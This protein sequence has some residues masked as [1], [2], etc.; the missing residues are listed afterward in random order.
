MAMTCARC[1][2]Q[3]PDGNLYCQVCGTPL[4]A[5]ARVAAAPPPAVPPGPPPGAIQGPPPNIAPP[6]PSPGGYQSPYYAPSGP[7]A[8]V[9]RTPWMLIIAA[10]VG[11]IVLM[12]GCGTALAILGS[13]GNNS[14][15]TTLTDLPSPSPA[16]TPSPVASPIPSPSTNAS[17]VATESNDGVT[18]TVPAGWSVAS[19][20]SE[21][22]ALIDAN[23]AGSVTAA[24]GA[25]SPAQTAADNKNTID[26]YFK[27][28]Y[29]DT[30]LCPGSSVV[31]STFNGARGFSW[32]LCFTLTSG[33]HSIPAAASL[34]AGANASGSVY[35]VVMVITRQDNLKA[36]VTA[37]KPVL[38]GIKW[39]LT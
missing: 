25:S 8:P 12:A 13:R 28:N 16:T 22:I 19:K 1:G 14:S 20:D 27:S 38:S 11:L 2:A 33:G 35:Y 5:P 30:R 39:K 15:G 21:A 7:T 36:Y 10:V 6:M 37:A 34:F 24:S 26:A 29:P 23:G 9:H 4:T 32:S 18:M 17:G 31:S 3:N